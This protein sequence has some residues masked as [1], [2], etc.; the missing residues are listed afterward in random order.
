MSYC[1]QNFHSRSSKLTELHS[2]VFK[3]TSIS[4]Q[5]FEHEADQGASSESVASAM[6]LQRLQLTR[7]CIRTT[8]STPKP[9]SCRPWSAT[10]NAAVVD[11]W[12]CC[13]SAGVGAFSFEL[14]RLS[15]STRT[16]AAS[17]AARFLFS[18]MCFFTKLKYALQSSLVAGVEDDGC[19]AMAAATAFHFASPLSVLSIAFRAFCRTTHFSPS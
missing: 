7:R 17:L 12:G 2:S 19:D 8:W 10:R 5:H 18:L 11:R 6:V 4:A 1:K 13:S 14:P 15:W 9:C 16:S 3:F